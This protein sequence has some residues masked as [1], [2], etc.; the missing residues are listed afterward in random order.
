MEGRTSKAALARSLGVSR[1][2]LYYRPRRPAKD[3]V[4]REKILT[5]MADNPAYGSRSVG[6]ALGRNRKP[7][8]RIKQL[9][10]LYP[11]IRRKG[12]YQRFSREITP[13][14]IP[15]RLKDLCPI[16]PDAI[17]VGDFT[18]LWFHGRYIYFATVLDYFTREVIAWQLGLHHTSRL[19]IDVLE[20]GKRKRE[21]TPQLFHSDQGSEYT[22]QDCVRW[23]LHHRIMPSNSPKG[24]PWTN[25]RQESFYS[26]FKLEFG[27]PSTHPTIEALTEALGRHIHYYNSRRIHSALHMAPRQFCEQRRYPRV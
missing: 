5:V 20:E 19:V 24:K 1:S 11:R 10:H 2:S 14:P 25:G 22:S 15:N 8:Q 4:L 27:K 9:Y 6:W 13:A 23:L 16:Q 26:S 21:T 18:H 17:W 3:E 7:I 12:R